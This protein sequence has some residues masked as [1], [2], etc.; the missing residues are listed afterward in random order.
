MGFSLLCFTLTI[1]AYTRF[2]KHIFKTVQFF[3]DFLGNSLNNV[4]LLISGC[5]IGTFLIGDSTITYWDVIY[6]LGSYVLLHLVRFLWL[7]MFFPIMKNYGYGFSMEKVLLMT[8][9]TFKDYKTFIVA[10]LVYEDSHH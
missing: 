9:A 4:A 8:V 5:I 6:L 2:D 7:M 10:M 1:S 3:W